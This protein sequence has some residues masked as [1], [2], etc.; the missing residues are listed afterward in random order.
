[1]KSFLQT[2]RTTSSR[3]SKQRARIRAILAVVGIAVLLLYTKDILGTLSSMVTLPLYEFKHYL[4][5]SSATVPSYL[6]DRT[7]LIAEIRE[8][9]AQIA[10]QQGI[11]MTLAEAMRE[12]DELRELLRVPPTERIAAGVIARPP[13]TPYDTLILDQGSEAGIVEHAPVFFGNGIAIGYVRSV[14]RENALVTLFSSPGVESV[15]YVFGPNIFAR[16]YGEGG[17]IT[18]IRI[19]Q[20][21][22]VAEGDMVVLPSLDG[23]VYGTI[24][25]VESTPT[26]PEQYAFTGLAAPL[27]SIRLVSVGTRSVE[28]VTFDEAVLVTEEAARTLFTFPIPEGNEG[29]IGTST[30]TTSIET[31]STTTP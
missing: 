13:Y 20:G 19:P 11:T 23:G 16:A 10:S 28:P 15:V 1:M 7:A 6:R 12:N 14:T 31:I 22:T 4:Q 21:M 17:G 3:N 25:A 8:L 2:T 29:G 26:G 24:D 9:E 30:P 5:H 18:R 27:S